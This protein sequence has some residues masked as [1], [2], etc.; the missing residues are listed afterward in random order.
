MLC[1]LQTLLLLQA[2][3][4]VVTGRRGDEIGGSRSVRDLPSHVFCSF[5]GFEFTVLGE[6]EEGL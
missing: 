4:H 1:V 2:R 5:S 3:E 6:E